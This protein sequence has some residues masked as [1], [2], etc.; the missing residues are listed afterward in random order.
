MFQTVTWFLYPSFLSLTAKGSLCLCHLFQLLELTA[1]QAHLAEDTAFLANQIQRRIEFR[2]H[3]FVKD[4]LWTHLAATVSPEDLY[5]HQPVIVYYGTYTVRD[6]QK[7]GIGKFSSD[8][9]LNLRVRLEVDATGV[10]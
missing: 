6:C 8:G 5:T 10:V 7:T 2:N 3:T 1:L 9:G 4:D